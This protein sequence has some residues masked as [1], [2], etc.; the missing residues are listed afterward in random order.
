MDFADIVGGA[1][2]ASSLCLLY[3]EDVLFLGCSSNKGGVFVVSERSTLFIKNS[4]FI[5]NSA[6]EGGVF[7]CYEN[8]NYEVTIENCYFR[9][10]SG[11]EN[12]FNLMVSIFLISDS[13]FELNQNPLFSLTQTQ[14]YLNNVNVSDHFCQ[15]QVI[16]CLIN[17]IENSSIFSDHLILFEINNTMEEGNIYLESSIGI[18]TMVNFTEMS[19]LKSIGSCFD[20]E[21]AELFVNDCTF[22]TFD[23]NCIFGLGSI[24]EINNTVFDNQNQESSYGIQYENEKMGAVYCESCLSFISFNSTFR[25]NLMADSGGS[26]TLISNDDDFS[27][28]ASLTNLSF[29][30]NQANAQGGALYLNN[31]NSIIMNCQFIKNKAMFGAAIYFVSTCIFILFLSYSLKL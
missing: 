20:L 16:G 18:F 30:E 14:L 24:I 23:S 22:T 2:G 12:L 27:Y 28:I 7:H 29:I 9:N 25:F 11:S 5:D 19:N 6:D 17:A 10:N 8:Y 26:L 15:I 31:V 21:N 13:V 3:I 1:I 4:T